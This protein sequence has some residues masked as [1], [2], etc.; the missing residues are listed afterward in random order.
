MLIILNSFL[1]SGINYRITDGVNV[2]NTEEVGDLEW[3]IY[4]MTYGAEKTGSTAAQIAVSGDANFSKLISKSTKWPNPGYRAGWYFLDDRCTAGCFNVYNT[5]DHSASDLYETGRED[6]GVGTYQIRALAYG[7]GPNPRSIEGD[8]W[9][10]WDYDCGSPITCDL[11]YCEY[12]ETSSP[13]CNALMNPQASKC[14]TCETDSN[15]CNE[16]DANNGYLCN[17]VRVIVEFYDN[18]HALPGDFQQITSD[19]WVD[20]DNDEK[21]YTDPTYGEIFITDINPGTVD[22]RQTITITSGCTDPSECTDR[23]C[24]DPTCVSYTCGEVLVARGSTDSG[25]AD[26]CDGAGACVECTARSHCPADYWTVN[27]KCDGD[28]PQREKIEYSCSSDTCVSDNN[29][30]D[31]GLPCVTDGGCYDGSCCTKSCGDGSECGDDKCGDPNGCGTCNPGDTCS[32]DVCVPNGNAYWADMSGVKIGES[33][34]RDYAD[35]IDT[36]LLIYKDKAGAG[37]N[38]DI[39]E[40]AGGPRGFGGSDNHVR[41]IFAA[42]TFDYDGHRAAKWV[43]NGS[44][45]FDIFA[46]DVGGFYEG[47]FYFQVD[48]ELSNNL[49]VNDTL[50]ESS[51]NSPSVR[52]VEPKLREKVGTDDACPVDFNQSASD[53]DNDLKIKWIYEGGDESDWFLNC[54]T[55]NNCNTTHFYTESGT[56]IIEIIAR[57]MNGSLEAVNNSQVFAYGGGINVLPDITKPPFG[58]IFAGTDEAR[59]IEFNANESYVA[60]CSLIEASCDSASPD[61]YGVCNLFCYDFD[62]E[63]DIPSKYDFFLSWVFS[64]V[65][66]YLGREGLWSEKYD[67]IVEF[68]RLF[69]G[70]I[71]H[72]ARVRM[73]YQPK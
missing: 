6:V 34:I 31:E 58:K 32:V 51:Y 53:I 62:N 30:Y 20:Y 38:F 40:D 10:G 63:V 28:Q 3:S 27:Y 52:I 2:Y 66:T 46:D 55:S 71:E 49:K 45:D 11:G 5:F 25:C 73:E 29:W 24:W 16:F 65:T 44:K 42:D 56:K 43:I 35:A 18:G 9:A 13:I 26:Y 1:I 67:E 72:W 48:S 70:P 47:I 41:T 50:T 39:Y 15:S 61:C 22:I 68:Y 59:L 17:G 33:G 8:G 19:A 4:F 7:D 57:E 21:I 54:L 64:D 37:Y 60:N 36:V 69:S 23:V 12:F 14:P